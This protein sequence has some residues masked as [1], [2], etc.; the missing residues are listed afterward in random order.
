MNTISIDTE[1]GE[2]FVTERASSSN[3]G[4]RT[5]ARVYVSSDSTFNIIE[6]LSN[7][8][9]R[10]FRQWRV[11]AAAAIA[12]SGLDIDTTRMGWDQN[13]GCSCGCSP[14]FVLDNR[15]P[16]TVNDEMVYYYDV[17]VTLKGAQTVDESKPGRELVS[18]L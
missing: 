16:V 14:G 5:K 7:R 17:H 9:R 1:F 10:P 8:R 2:V 18:V 11:G 3:R 4:Y 12:A 13:A 6:D 15:R